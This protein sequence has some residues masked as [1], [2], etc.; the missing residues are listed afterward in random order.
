MLDIKGYVETPTTLVDLM[1]EKL[2]KHG[3]PRIGSTVLVP[4]CGKGTFIEGITRWCQKHN[5]PVPQ[6]VGIEIDTDRAA[7]AKKDLQ[8]T[9]MF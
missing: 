7:I 4:G 2:F 3:S 1:V 8:N 6:I 5:S 9:Q